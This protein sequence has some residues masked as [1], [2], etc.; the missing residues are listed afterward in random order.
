MVKKSFLLTVI[1]VALLIP[2]MN[3][4]GQADT[5]APV[6]SP[7]DNWGLTPLGPT[8]PR[9]QWKPAPIKRALKTNFKSLRAAGRPLALAANG[10]AGAV[11]VLPQKPNAS[12]RQAA[13]LLQ[14]VLAAMSGAK[15]TIVSE[16][17]VPAQSVG[18]DQKILV[19]GQTFETL[20]S[21]GD[22]QL[23]KAA[24]VNANDLNP[25]GYRL[26]TRGNTLFLVG[27]DAPPHL[28]AEGAPVKSN[29][30]GPTHYIHAN[31]TR[32][33][34]Y[35]LLE[36]H[37]GCRWLWPSEA[38][39]E[40]LP[41]KN[42][43]TL[44]PLNESDEPAIAQRGIR[45][46]YPESGVNSYGRRQQQSV[47]SL[48]HRSYSGFLKKAE[49][50]G[51][52][53]D[54]MKLG[55]SVELNLGHSYG[56][57]WKRY[58]ETH[59][60]YFA[61]QADGTR[62]QVRLGESY[63]GRAHLDVSNPELIQH[64]AGEVIQKFDADP[65]LT[66]VSIAPNDG[67]YPSFCLCEV[68][69]RLDPPNGDPV[70]FSIVDESGTASRIQYVSLSDRYVLFYS[71]IAEIVAKKHP[72]R[73]LGAYAYST[74]SS[75]PL[76]AKLAPN[77]FIAYVGLSYF[78]DAQRQHDL[79]SWDQWSQTAEK[80]QLRPN[81]LLG[82]YGIAANYAHK[83]GADIKHAYQTG[84][85]GTD[86][87]SLTHDW[88]ARGLN[89]YVLAKL[90][91]DPSQN[92]DALIK[93]YCD[94]GFGPASPAIQK[95]FAQL[96]ALTDAVAR[97]AADSSRVEDGI[98][99]NSRNGGLLLL[100]KIY[101]PEKLDELQ[102]ILDDAKKQAG[103]NEE[104]VKRIEFLEQ[105]VRYAK[106]ETAWLRAYFAPASPEKK[107]NVLSA[108]DARQAVLVDIYDNHFY[109]QSPF[110]VL[111]REGSMFKEYD[112]QPKKMP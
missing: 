45:N 69:R 54:A 46:Y 52:W 53:F 19:G 2:L 87:D 23:A 90:L 24:G 95:Y 6:K 71:K 86:F 7:R 36:R 34:A 56:D 20:I 94:A 60:E 73:L 79:Q 18:A 43:L 3:S 108:L 110:A 51:A 15:L 38:G 62:N 66:S 112:W 99:P 27:R 80:L 32:N 22:T 33:G 58:G 10:K 101:T 83:L 11:L 17:K 105:A 104:V 67:S 89:D 96:E 81:A 48:L 111:Y 103:Q 30:T 91:W 74:Y 72:D 16:E 68:C 70:S 82:N 59:P 28:D 63:A 40:V 13:E 42:T 98:D 44:Q 37:F 21:I 85:I 76:Y 29:G 31:G 102:S 9:P 78:N 75:P 49:N 5:S 25:D 41:K 106:A 92:I 61:L 26:Q 50:S 14:R 55:Q 4:C 65:N 88:A 93:D 64:I 84:M 97:A 100:S 109:A 1:S 39:G 8:V 35:A 12:E 107:Q 47:L 57:Y 77:V